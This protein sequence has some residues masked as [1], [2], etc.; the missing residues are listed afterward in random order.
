[1]GQFIQMLQDNTLLS[2][3]IRLLLSAVLGGA[4]RQRAGS[5]HAHPH[6]RVHRRRHDGAGGAVR[7]GYDGA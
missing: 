4:R 5:G 3:V 7:H 2:A 1:M 6:S